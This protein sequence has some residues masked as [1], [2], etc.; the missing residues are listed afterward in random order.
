MGM[1]GVCGLPASSLPAA[2]RS[3]FTLVLARGLGN[4]CHLD[5]PGVLLRVQGGGRRSRT[6][7]PPEGQRR[8][9]PSLLGDEASRAAPLGGALGGGARLGLTHLQLRGGCR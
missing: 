2:F 3:G 4:C 8:A 5:S 7:R 9:P 1:A 6:L